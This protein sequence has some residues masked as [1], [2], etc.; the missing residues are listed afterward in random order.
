MRKL[1]V[2]HLGKYYPPHTGG[3]E[4]HLQALCEELKDCV[5]VRVIVANDSRTSAESQVNGVPV[6]RAGTLFNLS[7]A[8]ICPGMIG[9]IRE[10]KADLVHIHLPN[11][12]ATL[13]YLASGHNGPLVVSY[14]SDTVRQK[15]LG[16]TFQPVLNRL[17]TRAAAIIAASP[18]YLESSPVLAPYRD[19]C[20]IVPY[21]ISSK[22]FEHP[23]PAAVARVRE[24]YG[25]RIVLSVGRLVYYKGFEYLIQAMRGVQGCLLIAGDGPLRSALDQIIRKLG[26][27]DRVHLLGKVE[28]VVSLYHA[29]EVFV[30]PSIA[31]SEAFGLVQLE[32]MACGKPVV[33]TSLD[34]GVPFVSQH[35]ITGLTVAPED[36]GALA[37]AINQLLDH[38][39]LRLRY[40]QAARQRVRSGFQ[41]DDMT[42]R[43]LALYREVLRDPVPVDFSPAA[44]SIATS[45][46]G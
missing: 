37:T 15:L 25:S 41:L 18:N 20:H 36:A 10:T 19:R 35:G 29:A 24:R 31:R 40:G 30:L 38:D 1:R 43:I 12:G 16:K 7:S 34:T 2:L 14:H 32:A 3:I 26:I 28:D 17:L 21:G 22:L 9:K 44:G 33:N 45:S 4:T 23:D 27:S 5:D 39:E 42:Q 6:Y 8:P 13:A 11:P 46:R